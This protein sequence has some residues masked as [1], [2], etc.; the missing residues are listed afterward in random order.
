VS[1]QTAQLVDTE[2]KRIINRAY[3]RA[4]A[5]L[6]ENIELLHSVAQALLDRET[7]TRDDVDLLARGEKLP[8]RSTPTPPAKPLAAP[9]PT[10]T[11][12]KR[13]PPLLGGPEP[14][15]A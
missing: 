10:A 4:K 2:V 15:P 9:Q 11:E 14:S 3:E 5:T 6:Q 7:L 1:E 8:P 12:P 13:N